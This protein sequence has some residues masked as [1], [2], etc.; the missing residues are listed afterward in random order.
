M[1]WGA[2]GNTWNTGCWIGS[3]L[4]VGRIFVF[5]PSAE[6]FINASSVEL[7]FELKSC[8]AF[9]MAHMKCRLAAIIK[10]TAPS[11]WSWKSD[12]P[13]IIPKEWQASN[14]V[15]N[16]LQSVWPTALYHSSCRQA[17][18]SAAKH[19]G[20]PFQALNCGWNQCK[21]RGHLDHGR[22]GSSWG[23]SWISSNL[24]H[25]VAPVEHCRKWY[26]HVLS[27]ARLLPW[28]LCQRHVARTLWPTLLCKGWRVYA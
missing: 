19:L 12:T 22:L 1:L 4:C 14:L 9:L 24:Q 8:S 23:T 11:F 16:S 20:L 7:S 3:L 13:Y 15:D 25:F 2:L 26:M 18:A 27:D 6:V 10:K 28:I 17:A 21:V 5:N